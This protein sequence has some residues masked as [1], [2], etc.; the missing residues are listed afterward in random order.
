MNPETT[1][2]SRASEPNV[3]M[4]VGERE[5]ARGESD[6]E[7]WR[8]ERETSFHIF[9]VFLNVTCRPHTSPRI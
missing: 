1:G 8:G 3:Y 6:R 5:R 9:N 7:K 2:T 4:N